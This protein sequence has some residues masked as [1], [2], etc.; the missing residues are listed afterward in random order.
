MKLNSQIETHFGNEKLRISLIRRLI[1]FFFNWYDF[2]TLYDKLKKLTPMKVVISEDS[3]FK[4]YIHITGNVDEYSALLQEKFKFEKQ[5]FRMVGDLIYDLD[6][7][8]RTIFLER[9]K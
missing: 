1:A 3:K 2:Y 5:G 7:P 8:E 4:T 6:M 9:K